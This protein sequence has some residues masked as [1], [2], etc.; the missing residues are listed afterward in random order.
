MNIVKSVKNLSTFEKG[1][2][3]CSVLML[4]GTFV[5]AKNND[6]LTLIASLI[7][8]SALIFVAKG[9]AIGQLLTIVF[10]LFYAVI[11]Y[12]FRYFGEMITYVGMTAPIALLSMITWLKNPYAEREVKVSHMKKKSW[13]ILILLTIFVTWVFYYILKAFDTP[14]LV[15]STIS[16]ATSFSASA[17]MV[18]RSPYYAIAYGLNDI[19]LIVLWVMATM[20]NWDYLPMVLCFVIFFVNDMYGFCSWRKMRER[21]CI[22]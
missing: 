10:S 21:Q 8:V 4:I 22:L 6:M 5:M 17:L 16:I 1:L 13:I 2:W 3:L 18:L 7:G 14:N 20:T 19:V 9:D 15:F 12:H 11:S